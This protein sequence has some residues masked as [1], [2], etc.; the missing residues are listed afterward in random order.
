MNARLDATIL[1]LAPYLTNLSHLEK[2]LAVS[3]AMVQGASFTINLLVASKAG[4]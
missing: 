2:T 1:T 4:G 3:L